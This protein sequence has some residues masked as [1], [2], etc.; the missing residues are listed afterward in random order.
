MVIVGS[1]F[2]GATK[3]DFGDTTFGPAS[4]TVGGTPGDYYLVVSRLIAYKRIDLAIGAC[5]KLGRRLVVT[6]A[7]G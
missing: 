5:V 6:S 3:V 1:S 7:A 4:F 2:I